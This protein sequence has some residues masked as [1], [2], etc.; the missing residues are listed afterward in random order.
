MPA[1]EGAGGT[2]LP[3]AGMDCHSSLNTMPA[4]DN[5]PLSRAAVLELVCETCCS[6]MRKLIRSCDAHRL[7]VVRGNHGCS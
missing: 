3:L 5:N 1:Q 6:S 4:W 2:E 7:S